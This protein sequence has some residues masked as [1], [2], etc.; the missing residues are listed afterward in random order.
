MTKTQKS[1]QFSAAELSRSTY[2][3][4]SKSG[5]TVDVRSFL[6]TES[7]QSL[8]TQLREVRTG[9]FVEKTRK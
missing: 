5:V 8:M 4:F 2:G 1:R 3:Q 9:R 7:G 6:R